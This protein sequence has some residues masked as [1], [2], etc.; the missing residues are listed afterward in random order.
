[1]KYLYLLFFL[2]N[3]AA[4][5]YNGSNIYSYKHPIHKNISIDSIV[6]LFQQNKFKKLPEFK[7][8]QLLD[9][10]THWFYFPY[11]KKK[12][13]YLSIV[14]PYLPYGKI[15]IKKGD[16][17]L[18][19]HKIEQHD[20]FGFNTIFYRN[21]TWKIKGS[22]E[23]IGLF[24]EVKNRFY[25][26]ND[27]PILNSNNF[28]RLKYY[29]DSENDFL[30][31]IQLEYIAI[32]GYST[33]LIC[34]AIIPFFF[35]V[36]R[37][38]YRTLFYTIYILCML[39][40]FLAAKG[41]GVQLLWSNNYFFTTNIKSLV[42]L[43][44]VFTMAQFYL[45]FYLEKK[46]NYINLII[47]KWGSYI[48][49][50]ILIIY[51]Y[52]YLFGGLDLLFLYVW[53][54]LN[55]VIL[56]FLFNHIYLAIKRQIPFYLSFAFIVPILSI[57]IM[58]KIIPSSNSP[59][60]IKFLSYNLFYIGIAVE[61]ILISFYISQ[62]V[63][64]TERNYQNLKKI[65]N[66]LKY[67]FQNELIDYQNKERNR[68]LADVHDSLGGYLEGLKLQLQ[69]NHQNH[70][71][72]NKLLDE[73]YKEYRYIL[74]NLHSP[75][76]NTNNFIEHLEAYC[77]KINLISH[78][79]LNYSFNITSP[80]LS[81]EKCIHLYRI[82]TEITTNAI[83]H[84]KANNIILTIHQNIDKSIELR[85]KDNGIG[86][87]SLIIKTENYGL[88]NLKERVSLISGKLNIKSTLKKGTYISV[89]IPS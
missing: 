4:Y 69:Q 62:T 34:M 20:N 84:S 29:I 85:I 5:G 66:E 8:S 3:V 81:Q 54:L 13:H 11:K 17:I 49:I 42:S 38:D 55:F 46:I 65:N 50:P 78:P 23:N 21:P 30:K 70:E 76:I 27:K 59:W 32:S 28:V 18:A 68:L 64:K 37:K 24:L 15:Y 53:T 22:S 87:D 57:L 52:K 56:L 1:M 47:F 73:F 71:K 31:R 58:Y 25:L 83:K 33:F 6:S 12:T 51:I 77:A 74:N 26:K 82:I 60:I 80:N 35:S 67:N 72:N 7:L 86:F 89:I 88:K 2:C 45:F 14:N 44:G 43:I 61:L 19:L 63:I 39:I 79:I 48:P 75:K 10:Q 40:D 16:S 41:V 36:F 9:D